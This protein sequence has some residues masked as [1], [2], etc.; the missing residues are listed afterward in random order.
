MLRRIRRLLNIVLAGSASVV[1]VAVVLSGLT[2]K[3]CLAQTPSPT[4][5]ATATPLSIDYLT[6]LKADGTPNLNPIDT[7]TPSVGLNG[8]LVVVLKGDTSKVDPAKAILYLNGYPIAGLS[9]TRYSSN[10]PALI[11]HLVRNAVAHGIEA[12]ELR[13]DAG[14]P[15]K[16]QLSVRAYHRGNHIFVPTDVERRGA[17]LP[18]GG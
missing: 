14:K 16:G 11:F 9:D 7:T 8:T 18:G 13:R 2:P 5:A 10:P 15:E 4:P 12:P 6:D 1:S 17:R 3:P